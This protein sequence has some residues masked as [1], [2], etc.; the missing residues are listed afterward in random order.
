MCRLF[1][2]IGKKVSSSVYQDYLDAC[3]DYIGETKKDVHEHNENRIF[4]HVDGYGYSYLHND[5]YEVRRFNESICER[6][7]IPEWELIQSPIL[8]AHARRASPNIAVKLSNNHPFYWYNGNE[9]VFA[10]HGTITSQIN[11]YN[12]DKFFLKGTTDSEKYFYSLLTSLREND[13][14]MEKS[15]IDS[16]KADWDYTGANFILASREKAWVG[17]YY[18]KNPLY[19]NM[20]LYET[21]DSLIFSSSKLE[22]LGKPTELL[23]DGTLIEINLKQKVY[24]YLD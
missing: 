22:S 17:T 19:Y 3:S 1:L 24:Y 6:P 21:E 4:D 9:Y 12:K 11:N 2:Q 15:V 18:R 20:K 7:P 13:W 14:T 8:L 10:H 16:I 23:T 5:H